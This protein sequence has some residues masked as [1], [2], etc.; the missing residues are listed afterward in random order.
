MGACLR[1]SDTSHA[2]KPVSHVLRETAN[3]MLYTIFGIFLLSPLALLIGSLSRTAMHASRGDVGD[4]EPPLTVTQRSAK[5]GESAPAA[6]RPATAKTRQTPSYPRLGGR[7]R[8]AVSGS[9]RRDYFGDRLV[10]SAAPVEAPVATA[11]VPAP[12]MQA[13]TFDGPAAP[14]ENVVSMPYGRFLRGDSASLSRTA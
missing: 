1:K 3:T 2:G 10:A 6:P 14:E 4:V 7:T 9:N 8:P 12:A 13:P 5:L 11:A